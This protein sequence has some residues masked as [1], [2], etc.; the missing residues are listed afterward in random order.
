MVLHP[1]VT[2]H[3][4]AY[5]PLPWAMTSHGYDLAA[6]P[7]L[8]QLLA[9]I[10]AAGF[11]AIQADIPDGLSPRDGLERLADDLDTVEQLGMTT[12]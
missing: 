10:R 7:P 2:S 11:S 3:R 5:N 4:V 6:L 12:H 9:E 1:S 8:P